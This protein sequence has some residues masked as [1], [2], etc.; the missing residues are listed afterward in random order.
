MKILNRLLYTLAVTTLVL[1]GTA[2]AQ[3]TE[4]FTY[5]GPVITVR[6]SHSAPAT[7]PTIKSTLD[8]WVKMVEQESNGK[9]RVEKY[10]GGVLHSAKDGF[11]AAVNDITDFTP[12]Y[13][14][15]QAGSFQLHHVLGLP[16]A[17]PNA[18]VASRVAEELYPKYFKKEYEAMG[19]YLANYSVTG[20]YNLF[21]RKP[22]RTL[23]DVKGMKIRASGGSGTTMVKALG[24]VPVSTPATESYAAFQRGMVDGVAFYD[25]GA[26]GYRVHEVSKY[27]TDLKLNNSPL[28]YAF[29][30]KS[31]DSYPPEVKRFMYRMLRRLN[32][33]SG[34]EFD[35]YDSLSRK[36]IE[37]SGVKVIHPSPEELERWKKAVEPMW[38]D[39]IRENEAKGLPARQLVSDLRSLTRKYST[40]TPEQL[41]QAAIDDPVKGIIDG[42]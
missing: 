16:F 42:M 19:V 9:I 34:N 41:M 26:I 31:F 13:T 38:E 15:Y 40:W 7:F 21:T 35:R 29:N 27:M 25:T 39:F 6:L 28:A 17:F 14:M 4:K 30:K 2:G 1:P 18:A 22:V 5:D 8:P 36:T 12:A 23:E 11:K 24:A 33:M 32:Q 20:A 37:E 10:Y 3:G